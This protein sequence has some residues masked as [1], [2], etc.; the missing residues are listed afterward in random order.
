M[1]RWYL[2]HMGSVITTHDNNSEQ[3]HMC[4]MCRNVAAG[5]MSERMEMLVNT[6]TDLLLGDV[7]GSSFDG[8]VGT[9]IMSETTSM[10]SIE[11]E[12]G[13]TS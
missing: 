5:W 9:N 12:K 2:V 10:C 7:E 3:S 11:L 1:G 6:C 8:H 13:S 4:H